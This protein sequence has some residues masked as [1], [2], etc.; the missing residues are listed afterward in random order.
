M[1]FSIP[2]K[3]L[4]QRSSSATTLCLGRGGTL[5]LDALQQHASW[6]VVRGLWHQ[7]AAEGFGKD[8][9]G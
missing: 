3:G 2:D 7:L 8:A 1:A 6:F 5:G 9:L 4:A